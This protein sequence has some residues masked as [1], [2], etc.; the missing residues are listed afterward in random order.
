MSNWSQ[1]IFEME[2][3][4]DNRQI[5]MEKWLTIGSKR[6]IKTE[7]VAWSGLKQLEIIFCIPNIS[8]DIFSLIIVFDTMFQKKLNT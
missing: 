5:K 4:V 6:H 7:L 2:K 1:K 3:F 8:E